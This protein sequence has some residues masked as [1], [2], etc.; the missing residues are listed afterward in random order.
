[1]HMPPLTESDVQKF[2]LERVSPEV[3]DVSP[4]EQQGEWAL[5]YSFSD[6]DSERIVRFSKM[7]EDFR[8]D[9][10]AKTF[11]SSRLPIPQVLDIGQ[12]FGGFYAVSV[13]ADGGPIDNLCPGEMLSVLPELLGLLD[14]LRLVDVS[15]TTGY[16]T[17]TSDGNAP[18]TSWRK[19]LL[20]VSHDRQGERL[21][22]WKRKLAASSVGNEVF[23]RA[24]EKL[25]ALVAFCPEERHLIHAD[26]LHFNLLIANSQISSVLDW[27]SAKYGDFLYELAWFSFWTPW[28]PS[29]AGIDFRREAL[30]RFADNHIETPYFEERMRCY[31]IH[32]GLDS[33]A[34]SSFRENW[35]FAKEVS[36]YM[37]DFLQ[38]E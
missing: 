29:M 27:G 33:L 11:S 15:R 21:S 30:R 9:Q 19:S 36:K 23:C 8:K 17:W 6:G 2:L 7:D 37:V 12:A 16:G 26:L 32:I 10:F 34:Y 5:A 18:H 3:T 14:A 4:I 22:G 25:V 24:Y 35:E 20:D 1:M 38:L 31:E 13:K 28:F